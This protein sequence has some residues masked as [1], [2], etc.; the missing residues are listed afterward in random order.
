MFMGLA[1]SDCFPA[2]RQWT[3]LPNSQHRRQCHLGMSGAVPD[4]LISGRGSPR[5]D[6][7]RRPVRQ[8][9]L[10]CFRQQHRLH[11]QCHAGG[12]PQQAAQRELVDNNGDRPHPSLNTSLGR[13]TQ[14]HF[15]QRASR[16]SRPA[17]VHPPR[18]GDEIAAATGKGKMQLEGFTLSLILAQKLPASGS[19]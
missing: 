10:D 6:G 9:G 11:L 5:S 19:G 15:P 3:A 16:A 18:P 13:P 7:N 4:K 17:L 2:V 8:A 1:L 14:P 12:N